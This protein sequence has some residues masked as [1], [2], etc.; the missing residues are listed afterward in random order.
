MLPSLSNIKPSNS[1]S[2]TSPGV[3]SDLERDHACVHVSPSRVQLF[4]TL[5]TV[6]HQAP[7]SVGFFSGKNT[8][9][10]CHFLFQGIFLNQ[11]SNLCLLH[12]QVDSLPLSHQF[13]SVQSVT[14]SCPTLCD[15]MDCN[16][17]G[18]SVH[19]IFFRQEY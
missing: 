3:S 14:Q 9:V 17:P 10:G 13:S 4:V 11:G 18:S 16:P 8:R 7:L 15:P 2:N 19:R 5:W 6:A 12:W 1:R